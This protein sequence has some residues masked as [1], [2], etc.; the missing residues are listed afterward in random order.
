MAW[1]L[2]VQQW[3]QALNSEQRRLRQRLNRDPLAR[4]Q[5]AAEVAIAAQWGDRID[6]NT[7]TVDDWLRLPGISI[8]QART[9]ATLTSSGVQ[10][11]CLEDVAAALSLP[12]HRVEPFAPI[13][14]FIYRDPDSI[15]TPA[16]LNANR[17][18]PEQLCQIPGLSPE[19]A[20][21]WAS[22]RTQRGPYQ[23]L[24]DLQYR[25]QLSSEAI[26][27]FMHYVTF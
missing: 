24:A 4:L 9:L 13:L 21:A 11:L 5:S 6:V 17:A 27:Q 10:L 2:K 7:A 3:Q 12:V 25:L 23:N 20:A 19:L 18:T 26:A 22:D 16:R 14:H 15:I 1:W 8:H